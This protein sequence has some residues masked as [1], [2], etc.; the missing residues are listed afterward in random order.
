MKKSELKAV[1]KPIIEECLRESIIENGFLG[2]LITEVISASTIATQTQV[3]VA[4]NRQ[5]IPEKPT[6]QPISQQKTLKKETPRIQKAKQ[7]E[8]AGFFDGLDLKDIIPDHAPSKGVVV[9]GVGRVKT[10][11]DNFINQPGT[12][13]DVIAKLMSGLNPFK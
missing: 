4:E 8:A 12:P 2:K 1:L 7:L 10:D 5:H 6:F 13:E 3:I 11:L 9:E